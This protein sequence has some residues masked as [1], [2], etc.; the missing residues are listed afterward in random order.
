MFLPIGQI[1]LST[2]FSIET[3]LRLDWRRGLI[4]A[5]YPSIRG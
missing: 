3:F 1:F 4:S 2:V 5:I